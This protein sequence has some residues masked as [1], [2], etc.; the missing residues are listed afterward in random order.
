MLWKAVRSF[1]PTKANLFNK[2]IAQDAL[3]PRCLSTVEDVNHALR[4][5]E[6]ANEVWGVLQFTNPPNGDGLDFHG[7]LASIFHSNATN[8]LTEIATTNWALWTSRNKLLHEGKTQGVGAIVTFIRGFC[9][10]LLNA[11]VDKPHSPWLWKRIVASSTHLTR[12]S[13]SFCLRD[14]VTFTLASVLIVSLSDI[15]RLSADVVTRFRG[16]RLLCF[17]GFFIFF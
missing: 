2:K 15:V 11:G 5:F 7:W 8:K 3:C 17:A 16:Y 13:A 12:V 14:L 6:Y 10:D 4:F 9:F 1:I